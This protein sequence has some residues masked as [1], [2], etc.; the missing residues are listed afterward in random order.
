M[1]TLKL[2]VKA[3]EIVGYLEGL[4]KETEH[5]A[6]LVEQFASPNAKHA[7]MYAAQ[8]ARELGHLRQKAMTYNLGY[9]AD[10]AGQLGVMATRGGSQMMKSRLLRDGVAAFRSLLEQTIKAT[11]Q[12]DATEQKEKAQQA[13]RAKRASAE[14]VKARVLAEE[15]REA[16]RLSG[17]SAPPAEPPTAS[18]T[19]PKPAV[20][21][22]GA[23]RPGA[24]SP[25]PTATPKPE[26]TP[27]A[28]PKP[29]DT[30]GSDSG[31]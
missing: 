3:T 29:A 30:P 15:A 4:I 19:P 26:T 23:P 22:A 20:P 12:A 14:A 2:S 7:D 1:A 10:R 25:T 17:A 8:L 16:A 28:A 31:R 21:P 13:E 11:I 27:A 9:V 18:P 6:S 24:P 5:Y